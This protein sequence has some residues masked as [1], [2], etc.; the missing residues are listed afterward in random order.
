M[1]K[2]KIYPDF[3][4]STGYGTGAGLCGWNCRHSFGPYVEGAPRVW[5]D[6][7]LA[8]LNEPKYEYNGEKLAEYEATQ[9]QRYFERQIR[10]WKREYVAMEAAGQDFT[11]AAVKLRS[12]REQLSDFLKQTGL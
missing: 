11:E 7:K 1:W 6:E 2:R 3:A 10:R 9:Q 4:A 12:Y 8:E 5:T